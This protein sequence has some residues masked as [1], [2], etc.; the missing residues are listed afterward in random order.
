MRGGKECQRLQAAEGGGIK[1]GKTR[2]E[3]RKEVRGLEDKRESL[4]FGFRMD[5]RLGQRTY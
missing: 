5:V 3:E 1:G 2:K 4:C